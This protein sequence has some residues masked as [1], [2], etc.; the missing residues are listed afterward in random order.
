[1]F[2]PRCGQKL[3]IPAAPSPAPEAQNKTVLGELLPDSV[4]A[5]PVRSS[6]RKSPGQVMVDCPSCRVAFN[7][8]KKGLGR[9]VECPKCGMGFVASAEG[10]SSGDEGGDSD[11]DEELEELE[12][13]EQPRRMRRRR[14]PRRHSGLGLAIAALALFS[15]F[16]VLGLSLFTSVAIQRDTRRGLGPEFGTRGSNVAQVISFAFFLSLPASLGLIITSFCFWG[17]HNV[18]AKVFTIS[19][20]VLFAPFIC[21]GLTAGGYG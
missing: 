21:C 6:G 18:P 5:P 14:T 4:A 9:W 11:D 15:V 12:E 20:A 3:Q 19:A 1:M 16:C 10:P 13:E 7:V 17:R 8:P 2:C